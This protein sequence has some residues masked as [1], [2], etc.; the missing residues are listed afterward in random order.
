MELNSG[1]DEESVS[2]ALASQGFPGG[3]D[4]ALSKYGE[5][6]V[7]SDPPKDAAT[8]ARTSS[9]VIGEEEYTFAPI[10]IFSSVFQYASGQAL[11]P[12]GV[13][14]EKA[15]ENCS[16]DLTLTLTSPR[17]KNNMRTPYVDVY[18]LIK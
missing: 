2:A 14:V 9:A 4:W 8:F 15:A 3:F 17:D 10:D 5:A 12:T 16:G 13:L 1:I 6:L 18:F 7:Y 11:R